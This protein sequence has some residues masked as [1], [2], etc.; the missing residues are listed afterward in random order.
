M[1]ETLEPCR[2]RPQA[3]AE[4][5]RRTASLWKEKWPGGVAGPGSASEQTAAPRME[6]E[7]QGA[8]PA[9]RA[10]AGPGPSSGSESE[11]AADALSELPML[12]SMAS[13][14]RDRGGECALCERTGRDRTG[15]SRIV[16]DRLPAGVD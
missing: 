4:P 13:E 11:A 8:R 14:E 7:R 2:C 16:G 5:N 3:E 6:L 9:P 1:P 10:P 15:D 12:E